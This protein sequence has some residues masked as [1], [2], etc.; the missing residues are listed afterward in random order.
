LRPARGGLLLVATAAR[1]VQIVFLKL[2]FASKQNRRA[3]LWKAAV[4][5][6]GNETDG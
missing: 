2:P 1:K 4:L 5:D 3:S 6:V